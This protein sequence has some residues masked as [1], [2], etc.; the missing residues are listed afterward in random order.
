MCLAQGKLIICD[1][2]L[3]KSCIPSSSEWTENRYSGYDVH[4]GGRG[5]SRGRKQIRQ[6]SYEVLHQPLT[7]YVDVTRQQGHTQ[8][9]RRTRKGPY[10]R[11]RLCEVMECASLIRW[12]Y[13]VCHLGRS[14]AYVMRKALKTSLAASYVRHKWRFSVS[15]GTLESLYE[16]TTPEIR[17][18]SSAVHYWWRYNVCHLG[19]FHPYMTWRLLDVTSVGVPFSSFFLN[20]RQLKLSSALK[21]VIIHIRN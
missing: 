17:L 6:A 21:A 2:I 20:N 13:S 7:P 19:C 5:G 14:N 4:G 10:T 11:Q 16:L 3:R 18:A 8:S 9:H 15:S 12:R 1:K